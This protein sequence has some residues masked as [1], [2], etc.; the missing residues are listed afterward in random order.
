MPDDAALAERLTARSRQAGWID[1]LPLLLGFGILAI[2]TIARLA[3]GIWTTEAGAHGPIIIFTGAWLL[4]REAGTFRELGR[5]GR[6]WPTALVVVPSLLLYAF[7]RAFDFISLEV[8]AVYGVGLAML[9]SLFGAAVLRRNWFPLFYLA[10]VIPPPG[11]LVDQF[12]GPLKQFV[13]YAATESL[14]AAGLPIA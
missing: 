8:A 7:S 14:A 1:A 12:T 10:F 11:W 5:P 4:W 13:S 2:P 9:Y 3:G 6:L